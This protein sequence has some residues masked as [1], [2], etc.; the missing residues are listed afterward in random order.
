[1]VKASELA[2]K[3]LISLTDAKAVGYIL[4]VGFDSKLLRAKAAEIAN[5]DN[6]DYPECAF[7]PLRYLRY[8]GDAA[9]IKSTAS[10]SLTP[11]SEF[12]P[13]P[14]GTV[15][16]NHS[17]VELGVLRDIELDNGTVVRLICDKGTFTPKELLSRGDDMLIFNDSGKP[18]RL[19]RKRVPRPNKKQADRSARILPMPE[20]ENSVQTPPA[21]QSVT[22]T[23]TP[24]EPVKDYS[25]LMGK[26]VRTAV[27]SGGKI[28]I[29]AGVL[30]SEQTIE[31]ARKHN[32]LVQLALHAY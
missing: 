23:R 10:L 11:P 24:G 17:G 21:P 5:D 20:P 25:F 16:Y 15:C 1:M 3:Q 19:S 7:V 28:I 14:I 27:V 18:L 29:P 13:F 8:D 30:V 6:D 26:P 32:K 2:G 12:V 9:V 4:R 31:L 22:V